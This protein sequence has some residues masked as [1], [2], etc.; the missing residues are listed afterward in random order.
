[1]ASREW[2]DIPCLECGAF[3][4][5]CLCDVLARRRATSIPRPYEGRRSTFASLT[6]KKNPNTL[7]DVSKQ[8]GHSSLVVTQQFYAAIDANDAGQRL[9]ET[10]GQKPDDLVRHSYEKPK[11]AL[12]AEREKNVLIKPKEY[13]TGYC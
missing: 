10:W 2:V 5:T 8:L 6:A 12:D 9:A 4:L 11:K 13:I 1:M 3:E 7:P